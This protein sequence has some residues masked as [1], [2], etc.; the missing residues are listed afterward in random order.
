M[1]NKG[2][3]HQIGS[4]KRSFWQCIEDNSFTNK[5]RIAKNVF[6]SFVVYF[7]FRVKKTRLKEALRNVLVDVIIIWLHCSVLVLPC[8]HS[9][10]D[11]FSLCQWTTFEFFL[12]FMTLDFIFSMI[13]AFFC[14]FRGTLLSERE[15]DL[16]L[17]RKLW[18][19]FGN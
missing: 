16:F 9:T 2:F 7:R 6:E 11:A 17:N 12:L 5:S 18:P 3:H 19:F 10:L 13:F 14:F 8:K 1:F 15:H 4:Q